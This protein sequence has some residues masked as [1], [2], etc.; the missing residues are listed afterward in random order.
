MKFEKENNWRDVMKFFEGWGAKFDME[1]E[2][3]KVVT[4]PKPETY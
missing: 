2:G 1:R 4:G 3:E